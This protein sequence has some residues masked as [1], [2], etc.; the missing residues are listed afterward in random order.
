MSSLTKETSQSLGQELS[1]YLISSFEAS[2]FV[3]GE[4]RAVSHLKPLVGKQHYPQDKS[5]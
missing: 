5:S 4:G 3:V 1:Y 2:L